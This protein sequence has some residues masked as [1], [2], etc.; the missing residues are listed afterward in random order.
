VAPPLADSFGTSVTCVFILS[1][2]RCACCSTSRAHLTHV[3]C[4]ARLHFL[5]VRA[6]FYTLAP[7]FCFCMYLF[8]LLSYI[9]PPFFRPSIF[10]SVLIIVLRAWL[11]PASTRRAGPSASVRQQQCIRDHIPFAT[12]VPRFHTKAAVEKFKKALRIE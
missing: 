2:A 10:L 9:F 11:H 4:H 12:Q 3:F 6:R 8:S 1:S 5:P 7:F